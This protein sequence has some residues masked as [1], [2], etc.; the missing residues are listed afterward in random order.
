MNNTISDYL[1]G[2]NDNI[3]HG[4][5]VYQNRKLSNILT[6]EDCRLYTKFLNK[7]LEKVDREQSDV[8]LIEEQLYLVECGRLFLESLSPVNIA[9]SES[10]ASWATDEGYYNTDGKWIYRKTGCFCNTNPMYHSKAD[11]E[12]KCLNYPL[13]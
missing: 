5:A 2:N 1:K 9:P 12:K 3:Y 10:L 11:H 13:K 8:S 7:I 4:W 6:M